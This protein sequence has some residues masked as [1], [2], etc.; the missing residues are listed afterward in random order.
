MRQPNAVSAGRAR[1]WIGAA[2]A[3]LLVP[4]ALVV[5]TASPGFAED[6]PTFTAKSVKK[7]S[8]ISFNKTIT[9]RLAKTDP[10]LLNRTDSTP[11][12][13]VVKLDYDSVATYAGG[14]D[15][16]PATSPAVTGDP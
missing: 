5:T 11:V 7:S 16:L 15:G 1:R 13:V 6:P 8:S 12:A 2:A 4:S 14:I 9:S 10:A 3:V